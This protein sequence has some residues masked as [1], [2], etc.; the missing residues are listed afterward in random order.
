MI[1]DTLAGIAFSYEPPLQEYMEEKPISREVPIIDKYMKSEIIVSGLY[2][3]LICILFLKLPFIKELIRFDS[4]GKY[5]M[6]SYFTLF[7]FMGVFNSFNARTK[8]INI[9]A[10]LKQNKPFTLIILFITITQLIIT[11]FGQNIFRTY[12]LTFFELIF[13]IIIALSIIPVDWIR[14]YHISHAKIDK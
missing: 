10:N 2:Q 6:T 11:Y 7:V 14:K 8:R 12:G 3:A 9:F 1:M 13:V 5:L 4:E